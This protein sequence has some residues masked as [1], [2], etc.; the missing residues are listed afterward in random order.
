MGDKREI[1]L[2]N[3]SGDELL[4]SPFKMEDGGYVLIADIR[5]N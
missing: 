2:V 1:K 3:P 5:Q 4:L